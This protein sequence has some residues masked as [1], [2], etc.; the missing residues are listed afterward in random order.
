MRLSG[1]QVI[2]NGHRKIPMTPAFAGTSGSA[3][4][5]IQQGSY[6][7][8]NGV[9]YA[10]IQLQVN[11]VNSLAGDLRVIGLPLRST[12]AV[13]DCATVGVFASMLNT[14]GLSGYVE[15]NGNEIVL[16]KYASNGAVSRLNSIDLQSGSLLRVSVSYPVQ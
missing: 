16:W 14:A 2:F 9:A 5:T 11:Q 13:T 3:T 7:V 10:D 1:G 8:A 12:N 15:F 6:R 4:Y